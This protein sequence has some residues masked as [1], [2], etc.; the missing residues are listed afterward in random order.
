M[1]VKLSILVSAFF[2][3]LNGAS[4]LHARPI[5][6]IDRQSIMIVYALVEE[7]GRLNELPD[8]FIAVY[9]SIK[10]GSSCDEKQASDALNEAR[11]ALRN[12]S[13]NK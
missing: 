9:N 7:E 2:L 4:A 8:S 11:A 3:Y 1:K 12:A 5:N 6:S 10:D 13:A